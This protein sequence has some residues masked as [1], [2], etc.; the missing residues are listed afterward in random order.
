MIVL[1]YAIFIYKTYAKRDNII[2]K[3]TILY[4]N[5]YKIVLLLVNIIKLVE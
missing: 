1:K 4:S 2:I 3:N 5:I